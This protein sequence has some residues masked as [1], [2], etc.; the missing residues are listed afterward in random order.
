[1]TNILSAIIIF[2]YFSLS[3]SAQEILQCGFKIMAS[4]EKTCRLMHKKIT[5]GIKPYPLSGIPDSQLLIHTQATKKSTID[6]KLFNLEF[7]PQ[8][9]VLK[10]KI[11]S[12]LDLEQY[13]IAN[14][15]MESVRD[16]LDHPETFYYELFVPI[17]LAKKNGDK[18]FIYGLEFGPCFVQ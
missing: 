5:T 15:S 4:Q 13:T 17:E 7:L 1:M 9:D 11:F 6:G 3:L 16:S 2:G 10:V 8:N 14:I 18:V 12:H